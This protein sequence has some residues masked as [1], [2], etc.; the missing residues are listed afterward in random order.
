MLSRVTIVRALCTA[1]TK[2]VGGVVLG[3]KIT[4]KLNNREITVPKHTSILAAARKH[5]VYIPTL[6]NHPRLAGTGGTCRLCL[7]KVGGQ[8]KLVPACATEATSGMEVQT[9]NKEI[10]DTVKGNLSLIAANH[11]FHCATCDANGKCELQD[12]MFRYRPSV[13]GKPLPRSRSFEHEWDDDS[14]DALV[15]N[16]DLCVRC[17]RCV[18]ACNQMQDMNILNF[19]GRGSDTVPVTNEALPLD[20][21]KCIECG[22]CASYC[23][24]GA[25]VERNELDAVLDHLENGKSRGKVVVVQTAPAPRVALGEEM[26]LAPGEVDVPKMVA[27]LRAAGFDG[28]F[29]T[30]FAAD[31]TI[32]EEGSELLARINSKDGVFPMFT[33]CCPAWVTMI[34]KQYPQFIPNLST[35]R[36]PHQ[37]QGSLFKTYYAK[38]LGVKPEDLI[39]VSIMPCTAKKHEAKRPEFYKNGIPDVDHVLT[40][41]E[42]GKLLRIKNIP[43]GSLKPTEEKAKFDAPMGFSTGAAILF[44]ATGGVMEAAAR[45]AY[46]VSVGEKLQ[47]LEFVPLRGLKGIKEMAVTLKKADDSP[48]PVKLAVVNG[49]A[50]ARHLMDK[51]IKKEVH[52]DFIEVMACPGGCIGGGGQPKS[53]LEDILEHRLAAIYT[54]DQRAAVRKSH[55]NPQVVEMYKNFLGAPLSHR[56]HELLHTTYRDRSNNSASSS[57]SSH[58]PEADAFAK[59]QHKH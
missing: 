34:E 10:R 15:R 8:G 57:V 13:K 39:V 31:L 51:L 25:I 47:K 32:M 52:Y 55:E 24:V 17:G 37:M 46:E 59:S 11:D 53:N 12:L 7:V 38:T 42:L 48:A 50:N 2:V 35:A 19:V 6:C 44:G 9:E 33:S 41:R 36:S 27:A 58:G 45:T 3:E 40:T 4:F 1:A 54:L 21:S 49:I 26:N 18:A 23:P 30:N 56:S 16:M 29:D 43:L 14:S 22:Q 5:G 28:V 20:R